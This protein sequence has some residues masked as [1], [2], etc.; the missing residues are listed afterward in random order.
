MN[1]TLEVGYR[2]FSWQADF[3]RSPA[4]FRGAFSGNRGGKSVC[5]AYEFIR[6]IFLDIKHGRGKPPVGR[7]LSGNA[8]ER[9]YW[10][11]AP[12]YRLGQVSFNNVLRMLPEAVIVGRNK[13]EHSIGLLG[14]ARI[15]LRS[16][17][18]PRRLVADSLSG[19]WVDEAPR[20]K[21][22]AW[23]G[24]LRARLADQRGWGLFTGSPLGGRDNW[25]YQDFVST[26]GHS[27]IECFTW[28]TAQNPYI[29]RSEIAWA[30]ERLPRSH[31]LRDWEASWDATGGAIYEDFTEATHVVSEAQFRLENAR[32]RDFRDVFRDIVVGVDWG[33]TAA[34]CMLVVG[35]IG[36]DD[37]VV[38]EE[39]YAAGRSRLR[40]GDGGTTWLTEARRLKEKWRPSRFACDP[41]DPDAINMLSDNGIPAVPANNRRGHGIR[42][43][44]EAMHIVRGKPG[45]RVFSQCANLIREIK[46]YLWQP[47][48]AQTGFIE[49]P[50]KD[51][52]DHAVDPLRYAVLELNPISIVDRFRQR[53]ESRPVPIG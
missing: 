46:N 52:S 49:E 50:A 39:S 33:Y 29:P 47:N 25:V 22:E 43:V 30:K 32:A 44:A 10:I 11:V 2:P 19:L 27:G 3:H 38:L 40:T 26:S 35:Q 14:G 41:E 16:A 51:A 21:A 20:V 15:E 53:T 8:Q 5:G 6:S 37:F 48:K 28:T 7:S 23:R 12:D 42:R 9:L 18:D 13:A 31:Y 34:G 24:A 17:E 45:L 1:V 4:R 36:D